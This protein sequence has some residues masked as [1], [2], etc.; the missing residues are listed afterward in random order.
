MRHRVATAVPGPRKPDIYKESVECSPCSVCLRNKSDLY[1]PTKRIYNHTQ[2]EG[3]TR[4][5]DILVVPQN[6]RHTQWMILLCLNAYIS[7]VLG[8]VTALTIFPN[9]S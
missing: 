2:L 6:A 9:N 3:P 8:F 1:V 4:P 7:Q 5:A